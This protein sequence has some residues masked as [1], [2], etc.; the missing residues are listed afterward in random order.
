MKADKTEQIKITCEYIY[1]CDYISSKET[2][3]VT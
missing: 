3:Y 2:N 1:F